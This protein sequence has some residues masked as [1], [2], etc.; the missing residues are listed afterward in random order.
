MQGPYCAAFS[1]WGKRAPQKSGVL[2]LMYTVMYEEWR[3]KSGVH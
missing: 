1:I 2:L 3:G